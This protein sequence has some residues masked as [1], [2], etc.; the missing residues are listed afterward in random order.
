[1]EIVGITCRYKQQYCENFTGFKRTTFLAR[2]CVIPVTK[3]KRAL[4]LH[5]I[6]IPQYRIVFGIF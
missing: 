3:D 2:S 1:V 5:P 4:K 6:R